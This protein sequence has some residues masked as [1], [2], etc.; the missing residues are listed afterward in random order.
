V[1]GCSSG[2]ISWYASSGV[3]HCVFCLFMYEEVGV[4]MS[5]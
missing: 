4:Y 2:F 3:T 5:L 1:D